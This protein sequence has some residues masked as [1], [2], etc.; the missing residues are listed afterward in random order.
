[1]QKQFTP[2][3]ALGGDS[4]GWFS[5][6]LPEALRDYIRAFESG[7]VSSLAHCITADVDHLHIGDDGDPKT[8]K[9][10]IQG[11]G[12]EGVR[13]VIERLHEL[14]RDFRIEVYEAG[15]YADV[16]SIKIHDLRRQP[17][18]DPARISSGA[19]G[20]TARAHHG[21]GGGRQNRS[22]S[23][24]DVSRRDLITP[25]GQHRPLARP[26]ARKSRIKVGRHK[27]RPTLTRWLVILTSRG[28]PAR[29]NH[30]G[31]PT[32]TTCQTPCSQIP[33]KGG[34]AQRPAHLNALASYSYQSRWWRWWRL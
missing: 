20:P 31:R 6:S 18:D 10:M 12:I 28:G 26:R 9:A 23:G 14:L 8:E 27:G 25:E 4:E 29:P 33:N 3:I 5:T 13:A 7:D 1:M 34:P 11:L 30:T 24:E 16:W 19:A 21:E 32:P 17:A 15:A 22:P 2:S